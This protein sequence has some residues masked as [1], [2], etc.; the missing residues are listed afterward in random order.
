MLST[1]SCAYRY[2]FSFKDN[3]FAEMCSGSEAG[4]YLGLVDSV[5]HSSLG[6][7]VIKKKS[8]DSLMR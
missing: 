6:F 1:K 2:S 4:S 7:R 8:E 3:Y 5:Y